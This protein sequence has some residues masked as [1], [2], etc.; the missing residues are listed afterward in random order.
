M[1]I[2]K[3][4]ILLVSL[5]VSSLANAD[6]TARQQLER[7]LDNTQSFSA[8]FKQKLE[9]EYGE[10]LQQSAGKLSMQRP[11]KFRWDYT[12]PYPQ[13]IISNGEKIWMYDSE[14]EQVNVRPYEQVQSS[15]V[16]LL[17]NREKLEVAFSI[18]AMP[19]Q[20]QQNWVKLI[21]K[22]PD[23]DFKVMLVGLQNGKIKTMRFL[24]NFNQ[25]TEIS[26]DKLIINPVF[27]E[28][29]FIFKVPQDA[30][31]MGDY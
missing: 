30:D 14:L 19:S 9:S 28:D 31:V 18:V 3:H 8:S 5:L 13:N 1:H 15:P 4:I 12:E 23:S 29:T 7:F 20:E 11:G 16:N 6:T 22:Q 10:L 2:I 25:Q 27:K 26:F 17:D 24:D 21:P